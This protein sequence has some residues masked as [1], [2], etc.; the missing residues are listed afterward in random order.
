MI[1]K[2]VVASGF[3]TLQQRRFSF[4][5][6]LNIIYGPNEAGKSTLQFFIYALLY[7]LKNK[8]SSTLIKDAARYRPW[9]Q[10]EPFGGS[11]LFEAGGREYIVERSFTDRGTVKLAD[12]L[13][14]GDLKDNFEL[15]RRGELLFAQELLGLSPVAFQ[16]IT[17]IGQLASRC[18]KE[19]AG[20]LAGRLANLST[21]G[22]E[23]ISVETA[24]EALKRAKEII[25][26]RSFSTKPLSRLLQKEQE[27]EKKQ[28]ELEENLAKL[29]QEQAQ[30]L[31]LQQELAA[32]E[33]EQENLLS[34]QRRIQAGILAQRL[35]E[36]GQRTEE[37]AKIKRELATLPETTLPQ[38]ATERGRTL[39]DQSHWLDSELEKIHNE[40]F[41]LQIEYKQLAQSVADEEERRS[42]IASSLP[43]PPPE[44]YR[45]LE[46]RQD[47]LSLRR[48]QLE[49]ERIFLDSPKVGL[50]WPSLVL[51]LIF[52]ILT[53]A[54]PLFFLPTGIMLVVFGVLMWQRRAVKLKNQIQLVELAR[55]EKELEQERGELAQS[56]AHLEELLDAE[57]KAGIF[58]W[59]SQGEK[60]AQNRGTLVGLE[61]Q[62]SQKQKELAEKQ[63]QHQKTQDQI[64]GLWQQAEAASWEEFW[65]RVDLHSRRQALELKGEQLSEQVELL[66]AGDRLAELQ[67]RSEEAGELPQEPVSE[68]DLQRVSKSLAAV[69]RKLQEKK[70]Q[71]GKIQG[72]LDSP[73]DSPAVVAARLG[74]VRAAKEELTLRRDALVYAEDVLKACAQDLHREFAPQLNSQVSQIFS[75]LTCGG[76]DK[77]RVSENLLLS[78]ITAEGGLVAADNLSGGTLDQLYFALRLALSRLVAKEGVALPFLMDDTF[79]QYDHRRA[80]EG[81]RC[82]ENIAQKSQILYFTCHRQQLAFAPPAANII[83]LEGKE[84]AG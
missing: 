79:V 62:I 72:R 18:Q 33:Q 71:L 52:G 75:A 84:E 16:N 80:K 83:E 15:D 41:D 22:E 26:S 8:N 57:P 78:L 5:R 77:V 38:G 19:L 31:E 28:Q 1:I 36:I 60:L 46:S 20:E 17:Y 29:W 34:Q 67:L 53:F 6:G 45:T 10:P 48:E 59:E 70:L 32:S 73:L 25:G 11:M 61:S 50:P 2:E 7:G 49:R 21:S 37:L 43:A 44:F 23:E 68:Q 66:L 3:G 40:L 30:L 56:L 24:F 64:A 27:L 65:Q 14:G 74:Q 55:R 81:W 39:G 47:A 4:Q 76:Y 82:L 12:A 9:Q 35:A 54:W 63:E 69:E 13:T 42:K 58:A 51:A